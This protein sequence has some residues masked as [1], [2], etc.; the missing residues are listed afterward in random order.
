M[1]SLYPAKAWEHL[2]PIR[3]NGDK[4]LPLPNFQF[5][6]YEKEEL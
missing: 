6:L 4:E 1:S 2:R 5:F 3:E